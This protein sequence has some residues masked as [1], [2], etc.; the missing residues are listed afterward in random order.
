MTLKTK[1]KIYFRD[2]FLIH[3]LQTVFQYHVLA[4][5][6]SSYQSRLAALSLFLCSSNSDVKV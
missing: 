2:Y 1:L 4:A 3:Y 6:E 5:L